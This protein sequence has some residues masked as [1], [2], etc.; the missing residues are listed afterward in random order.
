[1]KTTILITYPE[2][3]SV[4][5]KVI[6]RSIITVS[7]PFYNMTLTNRG[8]FKIVYNGDDCIRGS[9]CSFYK[10]N[11]NGLK[12]RVDDI[13]KCILIRNSNHIPNPKNDNWIRQKLCKDI[14]NYI[15]NK[16]D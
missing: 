6:G 13:D 16:N 5:K 2:L 12:P 7:A 11:D 10:Y 3:M 14:T 4:S 1:M 8:M 9:S 15:L